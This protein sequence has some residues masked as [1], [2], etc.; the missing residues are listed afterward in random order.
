MDPS[1]TV[2]APLHYRA[3]LLHLEGVYHA[4]VIRVGDKGTIRQGQA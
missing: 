2:P 3:T 4:C 1:G